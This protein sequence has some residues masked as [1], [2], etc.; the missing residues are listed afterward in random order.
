MDAKDFTHSETI[1]NYPRREN[2][3]YQSYVVREYRKSCKVL[4]FGTS[5]FPELFSYCFLG[6]PNKEGKLVVES[7]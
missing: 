1:V 3:R 2:D 4:L 7:T 5:G 6:K